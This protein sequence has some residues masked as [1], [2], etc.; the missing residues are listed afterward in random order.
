VLLALAAGAVT[1]VLLQDSI[2]AWWTKPFF[3]QP[4]RL[5][6]TWW[7]PIGTIVSFLVC[8][9]GRPRERAA[10]GKAP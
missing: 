4:P 6:M 7:M 8:V 10:S 9:A 3:E 1:V 5:A 2:L